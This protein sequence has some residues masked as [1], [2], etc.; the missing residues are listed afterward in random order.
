MKIIALC[1]KD[2]VG[3]TTHAKLLAER[4]GWTYVK[5]PNEEL[6][7]GKII[8]QILNKE[9]PFEPVSFQALQDSNKTETIRRLNPNE[10]YIFDRFK[11]SA[12]VY[13]LAD[14]L[15]EEWVRENAAL[16]PEPDFTLVFCGAP[17]GQDSDIY[18][19]KEYQEKVSKLF[20]I[21]GISRE[22]EG[23]FVDGKTVEEIHEEIVS[24]IPE[25]LL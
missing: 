7:S 20:I 4:F 13:G 3:K 24:R 9:L 16:L 5:F 21:E 17:Y 25:G 12:I 18:G 14:G 8:R 2:R 10:N 6:Y 11:L 23:I 22:Y 15:D 1:G 19:K